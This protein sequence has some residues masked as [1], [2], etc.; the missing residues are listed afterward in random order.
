MET[1]RLRIKAAF[2]RITEPLGTLGDRQPVTTALAAAA[3]SCRHAGGEK[4]R[5]Q[6]NC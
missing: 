6:E 1:R 5:P 3:A 2:R 4:K